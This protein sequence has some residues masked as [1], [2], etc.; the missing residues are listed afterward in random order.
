MSFVEEN[1]FYPGHHGYRLIFENIQE[2]KS[3]KK[4]LG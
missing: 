4:K 2:Y 1:F 3:Q